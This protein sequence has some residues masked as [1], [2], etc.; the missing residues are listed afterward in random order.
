MSNNIK[1]LLIIVLGMFSFFINIIFAADP[2]GQ[3]TSK[4]FY[5]VT[6]HSKEAK[7]NILT[8]Y[9]YPWIPI[10]GV[11]MVAPI[12]AFIGH[13]YWLRREDYFKKSKII[14]EKIL[15]YSNFS[16]QIFK[17]SACTSIMNEKNKEIKELENKFEEQEEMKERIAELRKEHSEYRMTRLEALGEMKQEFNKTRVFFDSY[18]YIAKANNFDKFMSKRRDKED[19]DDELDEDYLDKL[20]EIGNNLASSMGKEVKKDLE[21]SKT[22]LRRWL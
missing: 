14:D 15:C 16:K 4:G 7:K 11:I 19:I 18:D 12:G 10:I 22:L 8:E 3:S 5:N 21:K 9:F 2:A 1:W 13:I 20:I 17:N 6:I